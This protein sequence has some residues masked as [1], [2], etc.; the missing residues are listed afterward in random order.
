MLMNW[1]TT[2]HT[3]ICYPSTTR[4]PAG[5]MTAQCW[6]QQ[7]TLTELYAAETTTVYPSPAWSATPTGYALLVPSLMLNSQQ[8]NVIVITWSH[9]AAQ[10]V[11]SAVYQIWQLHS[12]LLSS[13]TS[14][15][16]RTSHLS[17]NLSQIKSLP[18]S[19]SSANCT[20]LQT[21]Q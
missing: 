19:S 2:S 16:L 15:F 17:S 5:G 7:Q 3:S 10:Q 8:T 20:I 14:S 13:V 21:Y 9:S 11:D 4:H 12:I 18:F 1:H 6:M